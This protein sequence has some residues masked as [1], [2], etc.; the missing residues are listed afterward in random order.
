MAENILVD[1]KA[2][3]DS[4][5]SEVEAAF[6][7]HISKVNRD[8]IS[9]D[10]YKLVPLSDY[11]ILKENYE[12]HVNK[13]ANEGIDIKPIIK[14]TLIIDT[15]TEENLPWYTA[16]IEAGFEAWHEWNGRWTA[17]ER[18]HGEIMV[19]D[20]EARGI[21]DM[22]QEWLPIR[23]MNLA[24]GIHPEVT[25]PADGIAYVATQELLTREAHFHSSRIMDDRGAKTLRAIGTDEGRHYQ[26]YVSTLKA[27]ANVNPDIALAGM[28]RQHEGGAFAMP[29]KKGI[30]NYDILA[31]T[32]ALSGIFDAITIL[33]GQKQTI[34]EAGLLDV[35]P[36]TDQGKKDREWAYS[37][38]SRENILWTRKAKLME[39]T[40]ER[41]M[42]HIEKDKLLP[43]I[44]NH[45]VE[46]S[47]NSYK[48]IEF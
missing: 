34:D 19:R 17:E 15:A 2:Q 35:T 32:I 10:P 5:E 43:F 48:S 1:R 16:H 7:R 44:L 11:G 3:F 42:K 14:A 41:S 38:S 46:L 25:T 9:L 36:N 28:R 12:S 40:R 4:I 8:T 39:I 31:N 30:K 47:N 18:S 13:W 20:I 27:L 37:I 22:S 21:L 45:T 33:E 6:E 24:I 23:E 26:F 29:G